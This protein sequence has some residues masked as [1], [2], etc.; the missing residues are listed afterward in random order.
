MKKKIWGVLGRFLRVIFKLLADP[1]EYEN[2]HHEKCSKGGE[3]NETK[4]KTQ[5]KTEGDD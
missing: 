4:D 3:I 2:R 5:N 1:V